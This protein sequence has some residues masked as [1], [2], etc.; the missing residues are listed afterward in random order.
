M[1]EISELSTLQS[2]PLDVKI[3]KTKLRIK[4]WAQYWGG[5][6]NTYVSFSGGKDSTVLLDIARQVYP[7]IDAVFIDTGLEYPEIREFVKTYSN[8]TWVKPKMNFRKVIDTYGYPFVSKEISEKVYEV[9]KWLDKNNIEWDDLFVN[10]E[11]KDIS[12]ACHIADFIGLPRRG[13][14]KEGQDYKNLEN[15]IFT[16]IK[17]QEESNPVIYEY[18][19]KSSKYGVKKWQF[20]LRA[21]FIIGNKCCDAMKKRPAKKYTKNT[22]KMPIV[23]TMAEESMQR[24][25]QWLRHGC[26]MFDR[27]N[28]LSAPMSFWTEQ[29]VLLYLKINNIPIASV[30]GEIVSDGDTSN[31]SKW[32]SLEIFEKD[33]PYFTLTGLDRTGCMFCGFGCHLEDSPNRFEIMR[34]THPKQYEYI[35]KPWSEGGLGYEDVIDWMNENGNL[36][37]KY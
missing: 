5:Y 16:N 12:Y 17:T 4:E 3:L 1:G 2:L 8:V 10:P 15:G 31:A 7:E 23:A 22:G 27:S 18:D 20:L 6:E 14:D 36:E 33:L 35:M 25:Q 29:D 26:N 32:S 13:K 30:Y 19:G 24:T 11:C 37:I 21:P 9:K 28:P 34:E